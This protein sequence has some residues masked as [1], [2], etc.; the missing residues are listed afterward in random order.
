MSIMI[1]LMIFTMEFIELTPIWLMDLLQPYLVC[2]TFP[3]M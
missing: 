2:I 1:E 3:F